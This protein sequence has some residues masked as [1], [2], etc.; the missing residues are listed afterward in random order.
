MV[1][2]LPF[3]TAVTNRTQIIGVNQFTLEVNK[4]ESEFGHLYYTGMVGNNDVQVV[5]S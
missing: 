4:L 2:R 5:Y 1:C 3:Q